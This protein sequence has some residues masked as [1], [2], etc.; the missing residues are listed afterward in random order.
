MNE[1]PLNPSHFSH[2]DDLKRRYLRPKDAARIT[3]LSRSRI[4]AALW[5]G[6]LRAFRKGRSWL[7]PVEALDDWVRGE[8]A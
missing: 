8:N 5:A 2:P 3:G 4:F 7:I 6:E 1:V